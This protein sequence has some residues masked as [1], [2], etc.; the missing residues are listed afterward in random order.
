[1][2]TDRVFVSYAR[3]DEAFVL[4]LAEGLKARGVPLWLDQWDIP[5]S[6]DWDQ[7]ID[8]ALHECGRFVIVLSPASVGSQQVRGELQVALDE[9]KAI[10]PLLYRPCR[11]PRVLR[12]IQ[13]VDVSEESN[14]NGEAVDQVARALSV[15]GTASAPLPS[16]KVPVVRPWKGRLAGAGVLSVLLLVGGWFLWQSSLVKERPA[17]PDRDSPRAEER[18]R[19]TAQTRPDRGNLQIG[20]NVDDVD[21]IVDGTPR[22]SARRG[23]PLFITGLKP[24]RHRVRVEADG[25]ESQEQWVNVSRGEWSKVGFRLTRIVAG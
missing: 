7:A 24:G 2:T 25:Y 11:V 22:G 16:G 15:G 10:V 8:R 13:R 12:L 20:V 9:K 1:M 5:V 21:V 19:L 14:A 23:A 6:A 17:K 18:E 3:A 4:Q